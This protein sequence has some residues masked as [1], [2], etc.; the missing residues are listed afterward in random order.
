MQLITDYQNEFLSFL[1]EH[2]QK[3]EPKNLYDPIQYILNVGGK[4]LRPVLTMLST[5]IFG[6]D[7]HQALY[8]A[9]AVEIFHNFSLVHDDIMDEAPLRRGQPTVHTKWNL[10]TGI[11]S[12]D[13]MLILAYQYF[14]R[15]EPIIFRQLAEIFSK[16]ALEVCEGQ[17][18]DVDFEKEEQVSTSQYLKMI[19]YKTAVLVGAALKM[20][21]IIA[22][23]SEENKQ[24]IYDFGIALGIA[25]QLQDDYLDTFG[26]N[27][28]G[29]K[30]GGDILQNKK[31][32]LYL[33]T[34]EKG[35]SEE[36][37]ALMHLYKFPIENEK[38]K[39]AKVTQLFI[40]TGS[41][42]FLRSEVEN[43]TLKAFSILDTLEISEQK[44]EI[45]KE[46]GKSLM[47]RN[48]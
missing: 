5:D 1:K 15:Y 13:A 41:D 47:N 21:A 22:E 19:T 7:Y 36:K 24:K 26:D 20:G 8:A 25:Y 27:T 40:S 44:K 45:L 29:K 38:E 30:I 32:L 28:F 6:K 48:I 2:I 9:L 16:T 10:N 42:L 33:N 37:E 35:S 23:T 39:I 43:Y 34:L 18:Y 46:F 3:R 11:L 31:T 4:R 17:Q 12:G 14:E